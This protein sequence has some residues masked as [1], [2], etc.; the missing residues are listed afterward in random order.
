MEYEEIL[1]L[2]CSRDPLLYRWTN[3]GPTRPAIC[4]LA[5]VLQSSIITRQKRP[6]AWEAKDRIWYPWNPQAA[7]YQRTYTEGR[8][9]GS[10]YKAEEA[11]RFKISQP[12]KAYLQ[13]PS[14]YPSPQYLRACSP[15]TSSLRIYHV[16]PESVQ[17]L[18]RSGNAGNPRAWTTLCI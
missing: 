16:F 13:W 14:L 10:S 9:S 6:P 1:K 7:L 11:G 3:G 2:L 17:W 18:W 12:S 8:E 15:N 5:K 4:D